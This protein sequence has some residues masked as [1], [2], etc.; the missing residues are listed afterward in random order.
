MRTI[1]LP[2]EDAFDVLMS[3]DSGIDLSLAADA[4]SVL[5]ALEYGHWLIHHR[6]FPE[7]PEAS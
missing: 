1:A 4:L 5:A 6:L 3:L 2:V 7:L